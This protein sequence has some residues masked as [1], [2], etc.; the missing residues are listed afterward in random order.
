MDK[1]M[2]YND[3]LDFQLLYMYSFFYIDTVLGIYLSHFF[4]K[5]IFSANPVQYFKN[6]ALGPGSMQGFKREVLNQETA[7]RLAARTNS[8]K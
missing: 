4:R 5:G 7:L 8:S 2:R 6:I 1:W 3:K